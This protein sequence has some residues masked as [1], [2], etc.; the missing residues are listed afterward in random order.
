MVR[1]HLPGVAGVDG[2]CRTIGSNVSGM[3]RCDFLNSGVVQECI[4]A[5]TR[6]RPMSL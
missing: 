6:F 4:K 3:A 2:V 5:I 1:S